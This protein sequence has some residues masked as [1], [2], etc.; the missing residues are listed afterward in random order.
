MDFVT[1]PVNALEDLKI[2]WDHEESIFPYTFLS[3]KGL[4]HTKF[5][6]L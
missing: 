3:I 1:V 2:F 4:T 5:T 6:L